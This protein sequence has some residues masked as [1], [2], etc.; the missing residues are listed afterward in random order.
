M[1]S[2]IKKT[3][4]IVEQLKDSFVRKNKDFA[5]LIRLCSEKESLAS[6][7][8]FY[9][10]KDDFCMKNTDENDVILLQSKFLKK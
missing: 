8:P 1:A 2:C 10:G 4:S 3:S 9:S 7:I 6:E 5:S